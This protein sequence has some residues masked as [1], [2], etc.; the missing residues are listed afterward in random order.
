M[1]EC[2]VRSQPN[3]EP[4]IIMLSMRLYGWLLRLGPKEFREAYEEESLKDFRHCCLQA[5]TDDRIC[6]VLQLWPLEFAKAIVDMGAERLLIYEQIFCSIIV[7]LLEGAPLKVLVVLLVIF[8]LLE[9][10]LSVVLG[11]ITGGVVGII[12]GGA[13]GVLAGLVSGLIGISDGLGIGIGLVLGTVLGTVIGG[14]GAL[15][16]LYVKYYII[17]KRN[18]RV[19]GLETIPQ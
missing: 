16:S 5:Y 17:L 11:V 3:N 12:I 2:K 13:E 9:A 8:R 7:R 4:Q 1:K 18:N 10:P 19:E 6:G 15:I 14:G